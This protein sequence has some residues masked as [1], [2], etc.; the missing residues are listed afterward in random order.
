MLW[1]VGTATVAGRARFAIANT[2]PVIAAAELARLFQP[3]Q[4][5]PARAGAGSDGA[6]LGLAIVHAIATAHGATVTAAPRTGGGLAIEVA[7]PAPD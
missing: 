4:R 5:L 2:G 7:F 1:A 3:F 6:G